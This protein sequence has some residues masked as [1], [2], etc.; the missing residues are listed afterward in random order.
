MKVFSWCSVAISTF[1]KFLPCVPSH[2][3]LR[4]TQTL[5]KKAIKRA[6]W[7]GISGG[8]LVQLSQS[9]ISFGERS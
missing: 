1:P 8:H 9:N 4:T 5:N 7:E 2:S 3:D 6:G